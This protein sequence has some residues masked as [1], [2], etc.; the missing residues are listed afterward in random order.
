MKSTHFSNRDSLKDAM[1]NLGV[2]HSDIDMSNKRSPVCM[3]VSE[4]IEKP[5]HFKKGGMAPMPAD[6]LHRLVKPCR[7]MPCPKTPHFNKGGMARGGEAKEEMR[8]T[9]ERIKMVG[10]QRSEKEGK[11]DCYNEGG[12]TGYNKGGMCGYGH[13]GMCGAMHK[14]KKS[15]KDM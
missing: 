1:K 14:S 4:V 3:D 6:K 15:K 9:R 5:M 11:G 12:M 8:E 7:K 2:K 10:R 13:G